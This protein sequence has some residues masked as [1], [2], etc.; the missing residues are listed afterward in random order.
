M[1]FVCV[2]YIQYYTIRK[3][4]CQFLLFKKCV[5]NPPKMSCL[6]SR[7]RG[8]FGGIILRYVEKQNAFLVYIHIKFKKIEKVLYKQGELWYNVTRCIFM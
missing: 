1:I 8:L 2:R 6:K 5:K 4:F 7:I 3:G